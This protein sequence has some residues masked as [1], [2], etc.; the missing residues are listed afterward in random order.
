MSI[1]SSKF[2]KKYNLFSYI[3]S[4]SLDKSVKIINIRYILGVSVLEKLRTKKTDRNLSQIKDFVDRGKIVLQPEFQRN[5]VYSEEKASSVIQSMLLGMPLGVIYLADIE[6]KNIC[7]DGQQR[8]TTMINFIKGDF[9]L[10]KLDVLEELNGKMFKDLDEKTQDAILD[11]DMFIVTIEDCTYEQIYFLYEKLNMGAVK[12][13]AQEIRRC[14]Y[15]GAFNSMLEEL[16]DDK[17][18][19]SI[20]RHHLSYSKNDRLKRVETLLNIL[21]ITDNPNYKTSRRRLLNEYMDKHVKD[22]E[23][24]T[25]KVKNQILKTFR[26]ID[27]VLGDRAFKYKGETKANNNLTYGI[28]YSFSQFNHQLIRNH[29]DEVRELLTNLTQD[30]ICIRNPNGNVNGDAKGTRHSLIQ[31]FGRLESCLDKYEKELQ[32]TFPK[33]WKDILFE[34]QHGACGI[35]GQQIVNMDVAEIDHIIPFSRGGKTTL[36]NAQLAHMHCN[37]SKGNTI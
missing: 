14:V 28:Y 9:S 5:Y 16:V 25:L 23:Q 36:D 13:N 15:H 37:R 17:N 34:N 3:L 11:Y 10:K 7:V 32:R 6:G 33:E 4:Q 24:E 26:L 8:L 19:A 12:L 1:I 30:D 2:Y 27:D 20:V 31:V 21:A 18:E 22:S 35:C 29:A